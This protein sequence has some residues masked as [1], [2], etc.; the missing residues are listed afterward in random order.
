MG[1]LREDICHIFFNNNTIHTYCHLHSRHKNNQFYK[2]F[3]RILCFFSSYKHFP[4]RFLFLSIPIS[5]PPSVHDI[6]FLCC[7]VHKHLSAKNYSGRLVCKKGREIVFFY[8]VFLKY[9]RF[10]F[11]VRLVD[12]VVLNV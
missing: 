4:F 6:Y 11:S 5:L 1:S 10:C 12:N 8:V 9:F 3:Q 2:V 7:F